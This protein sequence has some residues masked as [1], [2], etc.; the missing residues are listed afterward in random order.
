MAGF[1][2][3]H[4]GRLELTDAGVLAL[5]RLY[6]GRKPPMIDTLQRA[7]LDQSEKKKQFVV[8]SSLASKLAREVSFGE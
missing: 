4:S 5:R 2:K 7:K 8:G 1:L 3:R 6:G